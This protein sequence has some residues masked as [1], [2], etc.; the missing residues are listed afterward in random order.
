LADIF[1]EVD[2][3]LRRD[4]AQQLWDK[5]GIYLIALA[6]G[7]IAVTSAVVGW[8]SYQRSVAE[9]AAQAF[10]VAEAE[11]SAEGADAAAI[12]AELAEGVP[13]GYAALAQLRSAASLTEVGNIDAAIDV[14]ETIIG[15]SGVEPILRDLARV[16][17]GT[18]L[19]GRTSYDD[20]AGRLLPLTGAEEPWRN[21]AREVLGL[22]A[23]REQKYPQAHILFQEIVDDPTSTPGVRDR[24]HVMIALI[25]PHLPTAEPVVAPVEEAQSEGSTAADMAPD[26]SSEQDAVIEEASEEAE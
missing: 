9:Q 17:S 21:P 26:L 23:Y 25:E 14:Y 4:S 1:R 3:D 5:Y 11:A 12:F 13:S 18:L 8:N 15:D 7:I 22:G 6:V 2:D 19:V 24:A 10:I 16:K 20:L